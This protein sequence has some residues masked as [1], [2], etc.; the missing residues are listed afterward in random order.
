MV[1][2]L[3]QEGIIAETLP[4][5]YYRVSF[6]AAGETKKVT[7][8]GSSIASSNT[9]LTTSVTPDL[10]NRSLPVSDSVVHEIGRFAMARRQEFFGK[11][12]EAFQ[13]SSMY[14]AD[15]EVYTQVAK[16]LGLN[17]FHQVP[18]ELNVDFLIDLYCMASDYAILAV[19]SSDTSHQSL[20]K[21]LYSTLMSALSAVRFPYYFAA[22]LA[23]ETSRTH[24]PTPL[25]VAVETNSH[26]K[27]QSHV[28]GVSQ[29]YVTMY[30]A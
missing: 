20:C 4:G 12:L 14:N 3:N 11:R 9:P 19:L 7:L 30:V 13:H 28:L 6:T 16:V 15:K 27:L 25:C 29:P 23:W 2:L 17:G 24:N 10:L 22:T 5:N 18:S 1:T 21:E 26:L 8:Y